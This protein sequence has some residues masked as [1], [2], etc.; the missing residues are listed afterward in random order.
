[1][2]KYGTA[3]QGMDD[4]IMLH[5]E[6]VLYMPDNY[7][8]NTDTYLKYLIFIVAEVIVISTCTWHA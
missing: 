6:Y 2:E 4:N 3:R 8:E 5:I 7:G 1:V